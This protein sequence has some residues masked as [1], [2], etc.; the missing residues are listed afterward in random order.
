MFFSNQK[1]YNE[2]CPKRCRKRLQEDG[3]KTE[4][5]IFE[6]WKCH[7]FLNTTAIFIFLTPLFGT[8]LLLLATLF[9]FFQKNVELFRYEKKTYHLN[10]RW[11]EQTER[12]A[13]I[14][15]ANTEDK[16]ILRKYGLRYFFALVLSAIVSVWWWSFFNAFEGYPGPLPYGF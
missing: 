1:L 16:R 10:G 8:M 3:W 15:P 6:N 9:C 12:K 13:L 2:D 5:S 14:M 11:R 7:P 4:Y